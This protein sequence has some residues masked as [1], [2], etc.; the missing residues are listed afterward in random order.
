MNCKQKR[1]EK[2]SYLLAILLQ[3]WSVTG[4]QVKFLTLLLHQLGDKGAIGKL[5]RGEGN[6]HGVGRW[7][8]GRHACVRDDEE[9]GAPRESWR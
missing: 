5:R 2:G 1:P 9:Q 4:A 3:G 6:R 8:V 7:R